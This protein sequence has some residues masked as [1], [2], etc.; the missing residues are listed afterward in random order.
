MLL[1]TDKMGKIYWTKPT[2]GKEV[3]KRKSL[4]TA[5]RSLKWNS[6]L[7]EQSVSEE[8]YVHTFWVYLQSN[9]CIG[10]WG[11]VH[12]NTACGRSSLEAPKSPPLQEWRSKKWCTECI[13]QKLR[14]R[15]TYTTRVICLNLCFI[16]AE[17]RSVVSRAW[18][19][20]NGE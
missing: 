13:I 17:S 16:R 3:G 1:Y 6:H 8:L 14:T 5:V 9:C 20:G 15:Y 18:E 19:K 7:G 10:L 11:L 4:C 12:S 2:V